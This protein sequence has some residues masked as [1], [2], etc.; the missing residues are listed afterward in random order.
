M[1]EKSCEIPIT[2]PQIRPATRKATAAQKL[3]TD[4]FIAIFKLF[5]IRGSVEIIYYNQRQLVLV[6]FG[7]LPC[8]VQCS[9]P[10]FSVV[11]LR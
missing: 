6:R 2:R 8:L 9:L 10:F 11:V 4:A 3:N 1:V 5:E 7:S